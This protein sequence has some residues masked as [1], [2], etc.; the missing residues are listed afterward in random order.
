MVSETVI[1]SLSA[2]LQ[3][4]SNKRNLAQSEVN[5]CRSKLTQIQANAQRATNQESTANVQVELKKKEHTELLDYY[6]GLADKTGLE[7]ILERVERL[8]KE[9]TE[10]TTILSQARDITLRSNLAVERAQTELAVAT[11][12]LQEAAGQ[13]QRLSEEVTRA[14]S[15]R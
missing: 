5:L 15:E 3:E 6:N 11:Q 10:A 9:Q 8:A 4:A 14:S 12:R 7:A 2:A 1:R 13:W